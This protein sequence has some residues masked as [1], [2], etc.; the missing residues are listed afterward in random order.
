MLLAKAIGW[1]AAS[2]PFALV[3]PALAD[4]RGASSTARLKCPTSRC[5]RRRLRRGNEV[6]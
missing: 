1:A 3:A 2:A 4:V 6:E 5:R